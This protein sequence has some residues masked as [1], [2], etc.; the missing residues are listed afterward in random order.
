MNLK[1]GFLYKKKHAISSRND[2]D[3]LL[4]GRQDLLETYGPEFGNLWSVRLKDLNWRESCLPIKILSLIFQYSLDNLGHPKILFDIISLFIT[5]MIGTYE[6]IYSNPYVT[7][8]CKRSSERAKNYVHL[9]W[10]FEYVENDWF[11]S[12]WVNNCSQKYVIFSGVGTL[13]KMHNFKEQCTNPLNLITL[14]MSSF[15]RIIRS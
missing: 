15:K 12:L 10:P 4:R 3:G 2:I 8:A 7:C 14:S 6:K 1:F 11:I 5:F 13:A 9:Q